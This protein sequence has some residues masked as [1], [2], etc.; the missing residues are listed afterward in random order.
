MNREW[1]AV[2]TT[3]D[4]LA[5]GMVEAVA[6]ELPTIKL[7]VALA[8]DATDFEGVLKAVDPAVV[9]QVSRLE[10]R[11]PKFD[12]SF[13]IGVKTTDDG[14]HYLMTKLVAMLNA[15]FYETASIPLHDYSGAAP[16][17]RLGTMLVTAAAVLPSQFDKQSNIRM[18]R[19][20][21]KVLCRGS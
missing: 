2:K 10:G 11:A 9:Y 13:N 3:L 18:M 1:T 17:P 8:D 15:T 21:A 14:G 5:H 12:A 4:A 16:G 7:A 6:A 20:D 19:V